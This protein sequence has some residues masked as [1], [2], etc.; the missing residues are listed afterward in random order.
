MCVCAVLVRV[1][2]YAAFGLTPPA[3]CKEKRAGGDLWNP[4]SC[5][6]AMDLSKHA[7]G[8]RRRCGKQI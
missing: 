3:F 7:D 6:N 5:F 4:R 1:D 8:G 2:P